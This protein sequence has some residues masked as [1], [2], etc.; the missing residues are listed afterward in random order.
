M[1]EFQ[2]IIAKRD[3]TETTSGTDD[4]YRAI[5]SECAAAVTALDAYAQG[6]ASKATS[7]Q[8]F[9]SQVCVSQ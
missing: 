8:S 7:L 6:L 3:N 9:A 4:P 1:R 5:A 2:T